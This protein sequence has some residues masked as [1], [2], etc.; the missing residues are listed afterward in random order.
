MTEALEREGYLVQGVGTADEAL[1]TLKTQPPDLLLLDLK[2][3][4]IGATTLL[5]RLRQQDRECPFLIITGHGDERTVVELM[6][7]GA[8]DYVMKDR[9]LLELLP[10]VVRRALSIVERER[11]LVEANEGI[12]QREERQRTIIQTALDG[13]TRFRCDGRILE[14][15]QSICKLLD[16]TREEMLEMSVPSINPAAGQRR[17]SDIEEG[18][19]CREF[20]RVLARDGTSLEVEV[21]LRREGE[22]IFG[23]VHDITHQRRLEREVLQISEDERRRFG[24]DLH[25]GL[26]Q[27]L[28]ALEMMCHALARELKKSAP[29]YETEVEEIAQFIR[30]AV[31]QTRQLAHGLAPVALEAEGLMAALNDLAT[32]T[33]RTGVRCEFECE[34]PVALHDPAVATH[35]YRIAQEAVNNALKHAEAKRVTI[36]LRESHDAIELK[37]NDNGRGFPAAA[38]GRPGMGLQ[39]IEYRARLIGGRLDMSS[40]PGHGVSITCSVPKLR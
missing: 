38:Q 1:D 13:F 30:K 12:R 10:S 5:E 7:Q 31:V 28:T 18:K 11:R 4:E 23:F 36:G 40:E 27:Q 8:L 26:G 15:N 19:S 35:L 24:R 14:V 32:L 39:V 2:L 33:S 22:E 6:K 17:W 21:S 3:G 34:S 20:G 37:I 16:Y 25:D 29:K 9:G